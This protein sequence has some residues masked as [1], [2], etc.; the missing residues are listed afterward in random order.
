MDCITSFSDMVV[1][2]A[3][4]DDRPSDCIRV[5]RVCVRVCV[6]VH[7]G[8]LNLVLNTCANQT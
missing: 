2:T 6:C 4:R 1:K 5:L 3:E 7:E 8:G